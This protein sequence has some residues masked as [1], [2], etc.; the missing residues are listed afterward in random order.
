MKFSH[1]LSLFS[2]LLWL[3]GCGKLIDVKPAD[4]PLTTEA[5]KDLANLEAM[6]IAVYGDMETSDYYGR[7]FMLIPEVLADNGFLTRSESGRFADYDQNRVGAHVD[8]FGLAY[9]NINRLNLVLDNID[10]AS[11]SAADKKRLKGEALFLRALH[12]FDLV[13]VYGRPPKKLIDGFDLGVPLVLKSTTNA[14]QIETPARAKV[15]EV[16][17]QI[18]QDLT[19][20]IGFLDNSKTPSRASKIAASALASRVSLYQEDWKAAETYSSSVIDS[21]ASARVRL[22]TPDNYLQNWGN[23]YPEAIFQLTFQ[24]SKGLL[25]ESLQ[26]A[27]YVQPKY[28]GWGDISARL[29]FLAASVYYTDDLRLKAYQE[30]KKQGQ[31]VRYPLK[32]PSAKGYGADDIMVL[33][34]SEMY[35]NRAEARAQQNNGAGSLADLNVI[36]NRA[37][38]TKP[39]GTMLTAPANKAALLTAVYRERNAELGFEGH[40]LFDLLRTTDV[41]DSFSK[42]NDAFF[43]QQIASNLTSLQIKNYVLIA[44]IP[45]IELQANP[46]LKQNPGY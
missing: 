16:Y 6:L 9:K 23:S 5:V 15:A 2:L 25:N 40:R 3:L 36:H 32:F 21:A 29:Y 42:V 24:P 26:A 43:D 38:P 39:L 11:G 1:T 8:I 10:A 20:A 41:G 22:A 28:G 35:L 45:I 7:D 13:R 27:Y 44:R 14:D 17:T 4:Y 31:V 30:T 46:N 12:Y 33:R 37:V 34:L 18:R 19:T